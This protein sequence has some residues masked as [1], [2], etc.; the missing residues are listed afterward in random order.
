MV[1][2]E[3]RDQ[4]RVDGSELVG[5]EPLAG[6]DDALH[7]APEDRVGDDSPS[8]DVEDDG[9]VAAERQ[10]LAHLT[11]IGATWLLRRIR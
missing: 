9:G 8:A 7:V 6:S 4:H 3:V 2:V 1:V 5:R 11:L 10:P